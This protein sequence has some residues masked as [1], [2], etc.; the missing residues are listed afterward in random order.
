MTQ[1]IVFIAAYVSPLWWK[2]K[3]IRT[4][5]GESALG[6]P[7]A[8]ARPNVLWISTEHAS[9]LDNAGV[10]QQVLHVLRLT[11]EEEG[12]ISLAQI[13]PKVRTF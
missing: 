6:E 11:T 8:R 3:N 9:A 1:P 13:A 5:T 7:H 12:G 10:G 4:C 2:F